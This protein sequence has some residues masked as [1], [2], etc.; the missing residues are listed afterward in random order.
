MAAATSVA[1]SRAVGTPQRQPDHHRAPL[2]LVAPRRR[3]ARRPGRRTML[4]ALAVAVAAPLAVAAAYARITSGQVTLTRLQQ[5]LNQQ[6]LLQSH[7]E[8]RVAQLEDPATIVAEAQHQGMVPATSVQE[9]PEV[10]LSGG[11]TG[12]TSSASSA[13]TAGTVGSTRTAGTTG[14]TRTAGTAGGTRTAG[15]TGSAGG[16]GTRSATGSRP[17]RRSA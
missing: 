3:R 6:L 4:L 8:H 15:T 11:T 7:L 13:G 17:N 1:A 12:S 14:G 2:G 9:I 16:T 5:Q 10:P